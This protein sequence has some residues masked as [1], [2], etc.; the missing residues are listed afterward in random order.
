MASE[1]QAVIDETRAWLVSQV[2]GLNLCPFAREPHA[3]GRIRYAVTDA[4]DAAALRG[5]L[6]EELLLLRT[7]DPAATETTLLIHPRALPDFLD[8]NDFLDLAEETIVELGLEGEFQIASFH[9]R[10]QFAGT[11]P[12]DPTNR[13]NQSPYP[14]LQILREASV[15]RAVADYPGIDEIPARNM[16]TMR[17]LAAS[18][19]PGPKPE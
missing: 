8:Y 7:L 3:K 2:I 16:E 4:T 18:P 1:E 10:Y 6:A 9:P 5:K 19:P 17:R 12:D 15:E 11:A 13:T 14:M